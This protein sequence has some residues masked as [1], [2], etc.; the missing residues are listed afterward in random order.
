MPRPKLWYWLFGVIIFSCV[1]VSLRAQSGASSNEL[2]AAGEAYYD[3]DQVDSARYFYELALVIDTPEVQLRAY[4]SLIKLA[5]NEADYEAADSLAGLGDTYLGQAKITDNTKLRYR[6]MKAN[7]WSR[8]GQYRRAVTE[9]Q[10][11]VAA[12]ENSPDQLGRAT[13]LKDLAL[14]YQR[15]VLPDSSILYIDHAHEIMR[16][17]IDTTSLEYAYFLNDIGAV[18]YQADRLDEAER[19]WLRNIELQRAAGHVGTQRLGYVYDNIAN[20]YTTRGEREKVLDYRQRALAISKALG[21]ELDH[22]VTLYNFGIFHYTQGN[23]GTAA[24]YVNTALETRERIMGPG[25][26]SLINSYHAQAVLQAQGGQD[27]KALRAFQRVVDIV[28]ES[29]G[30]E[31]DQLARFYDEIGGAYRRLGVLDSAEQYQTEAIRVFRQNSRTGTNAEAIA[32]YNYSITLVDAGRYRE[33]LQQ[34]DAAI[35]LMRRLELD[36]EPDFVQYLASRAVRLIDAG[37]TDESLTELDAAL[38]LITT[39]EGYVL[40]PTVAEALGLLTEATYRYYQARPTAENLA[41]YRQLEADYVTTTERLRRQFFDPYTKGALSDQRAKFFAEN[42]D[43]YVTLYEQLDDPAFLERLFQLSELT[44]ATTLRD[45]LRTG[46]TNFQ[47]VP[48]SVTAREADFQEEI[49]ALY[50]AAEDASAAI[51]DSLNAELFAARRRY[52]AFR[53]QVATRYP[54]YYRLTDS[55]ELLAMSRVQSELENRAQTAV[56][57]LEGRDTLYALVAG[58]GQ[59]ELV[60]CGP[61]ADVNEAVVNWRK[62]VSSVLTNQHLTAGHELYRL[63]WE[64]LVD[65]VSTEQVKIV[66]TGQLASVSFDGLSRE[67]LVADYLVQ[68]HTISYAYGLGL[69]FDQHEQTL[70]TNQGQLLGVAPGFSEQMLSNYERLVG[71]GPFS[72]SVLAA[73]SQPYATELVERAGRLFF[74]TTLLGSAATETGLRDRLS[75]AS[76]LLFAT[77]GFVDPAAPL[78]SGLQ[79]APDEAA[80]T[81]DRL[82]DGFLSTAELFNTALN[83][84]LSILSLCESGIGQLTSGDGMLS[85][86]YGFSYAG[87]ASTVNTLWQVDDRANSELTADFLD[88]LAAGEERSA[89]LRSAKL[90]WLKES[91]VELRHPYYWSGLV[92]QGREGVVELQRRGWLSLG[93]VIALVTLV[94]LAGATLWVR[95]RT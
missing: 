30:S 24:Q 10:S 77:H 82:A 85:L 26:P 72:E 5:I 38:A 68:D 48:D 87:C 78:Q 56:V 18:Y 44:K 69:Y 25:H 2:F 75:T 36:A 42:T 41:R 60:R 84:D 79:L 22:A 16:A 95:R 64:P 62:A 67:A 61:L 1:P 71:A 51:G 46:V 70:N 35:E 49:E 19:Y 57:Y 59:A 13:T 20:I 90:A 94:M 73:P 91:P 14:T 80:P 93:W 58:S 28:G 65:L 33:A 63:L 74:A 6:A 47:G 27:R 37:R 11:I 92:L 34:T 54:R 12:Q 4:T 3:A 23:F 81:T 32:R 50:Y 55:E 66:P 39:A 21:N 31:T 76:L 86:A 83:A 9:L 29:S 52:D 40:N 88:R 43:R 15:M 8:N 17:G 7:G 53:N 45:R 89:A